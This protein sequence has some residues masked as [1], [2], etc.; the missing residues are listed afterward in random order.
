M[1]MMANFS[2]A[3]EGL[4]AGQAAAARAGTW[5]PWKMGRLSA[6]RKA[7]NAR[8]GEYARQAREF[9]RREGIACYKVLTPGSLR[10]G[11]VVETMSQT[12]GITLTSDQSVK[13]GHDGQRDLPEKGH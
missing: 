11:E 13:G 8:A 2:N 3:N 4:P 9:M 5:A 12:A 6:V 1:A 7:G 10:T